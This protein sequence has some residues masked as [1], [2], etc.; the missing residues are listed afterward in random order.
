MSF[1]IKMRG[2]RKNHLLEN[3]TDQYTVCGQKVKTGEIIDEL[4]EHTPLNLCSRC[5]AWVGK[6][7]IVEWLG[8][9]FFSSINN[10]GVGSK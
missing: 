6:Q 9:D 5:Y 2:N 4:P 1:I 10:G 7:M 8:A 3:A